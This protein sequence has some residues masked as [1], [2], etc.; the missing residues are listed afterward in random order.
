MVP[1]FFSPPDAMPGQALF[2]Y[3]PVS[4]HSTAQQ[5]KILRPGCRRL[6]LS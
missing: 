4:G 3:D 2:F 1:P 6:F 5:K